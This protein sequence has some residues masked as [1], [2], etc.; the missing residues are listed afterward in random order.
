MKKQTVVVTG[1]QGFIG[2]YIVGELLSEGYRVIG[3]DNF[4]KYGQVVKGFEQDENFELVLG[5]ASDQ[6]LLESLLIEAD[7][8]IAA[9]AL[10]GG[11]SY[12]HQVPYDLLA[13][14][15][16]INIASVGAAIGAWRDHRL[17]KITMLSS[18]MVFESSNKWP[19]VEGDEL[20]YPPP[21]SSYG[22][23]K[24]SCEYFVRA[25]RDQYGL[26]FTILRPFNVVGTGEYRALNAEERSAENVTLSMSHVVPDLIMKVLSGQYPVHILGDGSQIRHYTH[27]SDLARA[28]VESLNHPSALNQDFNISTPEGHTVKQVL[29]LIWDK[30]NSDSGKP[31]ITK[32]DE[33]F[34]HDVQR[35]IPSVEKA[36]NLLGF[37]AKKKLE[38]SLDEII[39]WVEKALDE[40]KI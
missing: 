34:R 13:K 27:G 19:H 31:L 1:S 30:A 6:E 15:E 32:S 11:I 4:S 20:N 26:P 37:N 8:F 36:S 33:P 24:L 38:D 23:Q 7:H 17:K 29:E 28:V 14:N 9:A 40:G 10:I 2:G 18:S 21:K 35:R 39:P 3:V 22:F 25:A 5:D 12:F 16:A